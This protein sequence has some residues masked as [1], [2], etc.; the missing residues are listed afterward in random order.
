MTAVARF[1][2]TLETGTQV[3]SGARVAGPIPYGLGIAL[4]VVGLIATGGSLLFRD[5]LRGPAAMIGSL[6]GTALVLLVVTL[7]LLAVSMLFARRG[8][9]L[10]VAGWLAAL[11]SIAYQAM[12]LVFFTPF[13]PFFFAYV[14]LLSLSVWSL[15]AVGFSTPLDRIGRLVGRS[16]PVRTVA[17]YLV[18]NAALFLVLWLQMTVPALWEPFPPRFLVGTGATTG[19]VQVID[20]AFTLPLCFLAAALLWRRRSWGYLLAGVVL[21]M[22]AIETASIAVDQW[23]GSAADPGRPGCGGEPPLLGRGMAEKDRNVLGHHAAREI[24]S[25]AGEKRPDVFSL[26]AR[27]IERFDQA[28][29]RQVIAVE[30][31]PDCGAEPVVDRNSAQHD[32]ADENAADPVRARR[33]VAM[34]HRSDERG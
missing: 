22:L 23:L 15:V 4:V 2:L 18:V 20:L 3:R 31:A 29:A 28:F 34:R 7:P 21:V 5:A 17:A 12:L 25:E 30:F 11:G 24:A 9:P 33:K 16:A 1:H 26:A 19:V 14:G 27:R 8:S 6:Q 32:S 10:A 13:N